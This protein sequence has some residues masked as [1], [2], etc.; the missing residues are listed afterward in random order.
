MSEKK[1]ISITILFM[2]IALFFSYH[3]YYYFMNVNSEK[4]ISDYYEESNVAESDSQ[5]LVEKINNVVHDDE[6]GYLGILTIP[7]IK[8]ETGFY[9][10]NS[11]MNTVSKSVMLLP[12]S[13]MPG[14]DGSIIYLAAHSGVGHL[15]YFKNIDKLTNDD[16]VKLSINNTDYL[17]SIT[18]IY[19]IPKNG[20]IIVN[21]NINEN[22]L[23]LTTCSKNK[24]M[25]LVIVSKLIN[26]I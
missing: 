15:A 2:A 14:N 18:D 6:E 24:N 26:E 12:D 13:I 9:N 22:Y 1:L 19:E 21:R 25:Q 23:I 16:L 4:L 17:Y 7:K 20:E 8:L 10:K 5:V 11:K 3:I